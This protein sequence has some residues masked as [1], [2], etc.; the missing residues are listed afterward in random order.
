[1]EFE[2]VVHLPS[3]SSEESVDERGES[4]CRCVDFCKNKREKE[5]SLVEQAEVSNPISNLPMS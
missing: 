3:Q 1:M 4:E 2:F 5:L